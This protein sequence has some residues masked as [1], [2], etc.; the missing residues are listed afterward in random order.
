MMDTNHIAH[1]AQ[2][3]P[4]VQSAFTAWN[5]VAIGAGMFLVGVYNHIVAAGGLKTIGRNLW[6]GVPADPPVRPSD[7]NPQPPNPKA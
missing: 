1:I 6:S 5:A 4:A 7:H 3:A 2:A